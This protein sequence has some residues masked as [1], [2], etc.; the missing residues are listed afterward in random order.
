MARLYCCHSLSSV[1]W[2][3]WSGK[4]CSRCVLT[5]YTFSPQNMSNRYNMTVWCFAA[6]WRTHSLC[7][8]WTTAFYCQILLNLLKR[9]SHWK[10]LFKNA[11]LHTLW[12]CKLADRESRHQGATKG[13]TWV[14][15]GH[16][17]AAK[18]HSS[19]VSTF[20]IHRW[21]TCKKIIIASIIHVH[22][23]N[24]NLIVGITTSCGRGKVAD[25]SGPGQKLG[26]TSKKRLQHLLIHC[27]PACVKHIKCIGT[28]P[29]WLLPA[30]TRSLTQVRTLSIIA[31]SPAASQIG[32][33]F[34]W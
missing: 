11:H 13:D 26:M 34:L 25:R 30:L 31:S 18:G 6:E 14:R 28:S 24:S 27:L 20:Q 4:L 1:T 17:S 33:Q 23:S 7:K 5:F 3:F 12:N 32:Q 15:I 9:I 29:S 19:R 8:T 22:W 21:G 10:L 2:E 16:G